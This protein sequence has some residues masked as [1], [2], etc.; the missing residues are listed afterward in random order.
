MPDAI[1]FEPGTLVQDF[2]DA[3]SEDAARDVADR[4]LVERAL[5]RLDPE[6]RALVV[7]HYCV[8]YPLPEAA[9]SP[10]DQPPRG[11]VAAPAAFD[12]RPGRSSG[13]IRKTPGG[14]DPWRSMS[15]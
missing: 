4:D 1:P 11:E 9:M 13:N 3:R 12:S 7:L 8:G 6:H 15:L 5:I 2:H 14:P 10:G